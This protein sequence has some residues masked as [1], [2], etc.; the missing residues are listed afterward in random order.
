MPAFQKEFIVTTITGTDATLV[1]FIGTNSSGPVSGTLPVADQDIQGGL[2]TVILHFTTTPT[3][4]FHRV[5]AKCRLILETPG[6]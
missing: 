2:A 3:D 6:A 1:P 5:G 4:F